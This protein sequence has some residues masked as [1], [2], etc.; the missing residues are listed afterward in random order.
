MMDRYSSHD[1]RRIT[2]NG[3]LSTEL[4]FREAICIHVVIQGCGS[5]FPAGSA[6]LDSG[7]L[8]VQI[9]KDAV[10]V[11]EHRSRLDSICDSL[12][13]CR[14]ARPDGGAQA[15]WRVVGSSD[16]VLIVFDAHDWHNRTELFA[17]DDFGFVIGSNHN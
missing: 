8:D 12:C 7:K 16:R 5:R 10:I 11:P 2:L 9:S 14:I 1:V 6:L 15:I 3:A 17:T 4:L 13:S